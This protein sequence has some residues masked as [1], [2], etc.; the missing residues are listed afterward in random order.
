MNGLDLLSS[1]PEK[2][3]PLVIFDPQYR[4]VLDKLAYGN[5]GSRQQ[6]RALLPQMDFATIAAFCDGIERVL[7]PMG[8]LMLWVDKYILVQGVD[9]YIPPEERSLKP[10]D[11]ITW[12][13]GRIGMGYR[14]RRCSEHLLIFQ[15]PPIRAKGVW[16]I[17]NIRD[18]WKES[19]DK[20]HVHGKPI[21]L[22]TRL[23]EAVT[24]SG[25]VVVDPAAG[26]YNT[27]RAAMSTGR[28]FLGCD[29]IG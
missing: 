24:N 13:K 28:R 21:G 9:H 27:M 1:L 17:H 26:G 5:E 4:S 3:I 10:V 23:I 15:K 29:L 12:D 11:M 25:D 19:A 18:V 7:M 20:T 2:S 22:L 6:E 14:T 8:H 16:Q